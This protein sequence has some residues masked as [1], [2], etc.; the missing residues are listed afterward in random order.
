LLIQ[1]L[2]KES[3]KTQIN[4]AHLV[5]PYL[6]HTGSWIYNQ[7]IG[8]NEV[9]HFVF[10]QKKENLEQYP[11]ENVIS[12]ENFNLFK[13][14]VN[15]IYRKITD[16][17]GMFFIAKT[18]RYNIDIFHA[19]MGFEGARWLKMV[20]NSKK[21][22]ITSFYGQDVSKLGKQDYWLKRYKSLFEYGKFF[23]A[24]GPYLKK[25]LIDIG[26][27]ENKVIIQKLGI[28]INQYPVKDYSI[29]NKRM[30][31]LQVST[32]REKK[33]IKYSLEAIKLLHEDKI[34]FEFR[35][36]GGADNEK[37]YNEI[38]ELIL[39][40]GIE[41]KVKLLGKMTHSEVIKEMVSADI[42]LHPSVT[43][44]DGDNEG[45]V[46]VGI[47]EASAVGLPVVSSYHAD[48]PEVIINKV[49][50]LLSTE[51]N[52][53]QIYKNL[54]ALINDQNC[55]M[56]FGIAA[57]EHMIKNYNLRDQIIKLIE[58]YKKVIN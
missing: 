25:Q 16:N 28:S 54:L 39:K 30:I 31:I 14:F 45:G 34:D 47:I 2:R 49:T 27:P 42:F 17:Y 15:K 21:P 43:A 46:P 1:N 51:K 20:M 40:N 6:F 50:G 3:L 12:I 13:R 7:I 38:Q 57:R 55:R 29:A 11:L 5:T 35:L 8:V 23:L 32:F 36:I 58:I 41:D 18:T 44:L 33:G 10:T 53:Y 19:H 56:Q 9:N 26:C 24:E 52:S 4:I 22:L 48:I 37:A